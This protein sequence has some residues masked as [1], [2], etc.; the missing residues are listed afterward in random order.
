MIHSLT[1]IYN[2]KTVFESDS[3]WLHPLFELHD[4]LKHNQLPVD[5]LLI[6]DKVAGRAAAS[7]MAYIGIKRCHIEL[8]SRRAFDVFDKSG[9]KYTYNTVVEQID[10]G[11]EYLITDRMTAEDVWLFLRK[12]A[13][14][15]EGLPVRCDSLKVSVGG[16]LTLN[17]L[18]FSISAGEQAVIVGANGAG[19]TT[20]LKTLLGLLKPDS[21]S[22]TVGNYIV[23]SDEWKRNRSN[24]AYV[25]QEKTAS[26]FPVAAGEVVSIG[27]AGS[28]LS[29]GEIYYNVELAM[30]RTGC[31]NLLKRSY[32]TLSGGEK[33]RVA[34]ARCLCQ[35]AKVL[36][37]DE[38]TSFLD[39]EGK[40]DLRL[41]LDDL[42]R[43][44]AP[45]IIT[46]SHDWAWSESLAW[47]IKEL[48][49][50]TL[51]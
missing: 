5:E 12:R 37:L 29:S 10:C 21:G 28:K 27:L 15:I 47:Q 48:K 46:V 20:F 32:H 4:F 39:R 41:L 24:T 13:G 6:S 23:G 9:I 42:C 1:V 35:N 2:G 45:T 36:L 50:G 51:C 40:D 31:F 8:I 49:G 16:R 26:T 25:N 30:R 34:I 43:K 38:P 33:Q 44:E 3:R 18:N 17:N 14:R 19:K 11:T 7:M 22:V